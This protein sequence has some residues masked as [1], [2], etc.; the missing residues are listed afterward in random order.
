MK[1][2]T[3]ADVIQPCWQALFSRSER[4]R[5]SSGTGP[6]FESKALKL[7]G[8]YIHVFKFARIR[9]H[10]IRYTEMNVRAVK[11][12]D[13]SSTK[14]NEIVDSFAASHVSFGTDKSGADPA[15]K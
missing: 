15:D 14:R 5:K 9:I 11:I 3:C 13:L 6:G 7:M 12:F 1:S 10:H 8:S 4:G 2:Y